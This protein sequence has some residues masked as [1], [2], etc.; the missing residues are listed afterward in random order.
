MLR[1]LIV[2]GFVSMSLLT[3]PLSAEDTG[4]ENI[5]FIS[6]PVIQ[7]LPSDYNTLADNTAD[8]DQLKCLAVN[9]YH[10]ARG[11]GVDGIKAVTNVVLNRVEDP[12]FP[13]TPCETVYQKTGRVCQF[14]WVCQGKGEPSNTNTFERVEHIVSE[15]YIEERE[16]ITKGALFFHSRQVSPGWRRAVTT[17]I[18][19]HVFYR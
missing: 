7:E 15:V 10:E 3:T 11:E 14:S 4:Q 2:S 1:N 17:R 12:R 8:E 5:V 18:G 13:D 16:D 9:A 19:N 6:T